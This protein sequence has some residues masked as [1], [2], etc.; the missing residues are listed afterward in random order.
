MSEMDTTFWVSV[1]G[2]IILL[3]LFSVTRGYRG[4]RPG[5]SKEAVHPYEDQLRVFAE[6][7]PVI[8]WSIDA[9]GLLQF[10]NVRWTQITGRDVEASMGTAWL[11]VIHPDDCAILKAAW[12]QATERGE[13]FEVVHRLQNAMGNYR[14]QRSRGQP[15]Q[16][17]EGTIIGWHGITDDIHE[18]HVAESTARESE[19]RL[20][21]GVSVGRLAIAEIDYSLDV[22]YTNEQIIALFGLPT[23]CGPTVSRTAIHMLVH[24]D[25]RPTLLAQIEAALDPA[26]ARW[27]AMEY[28]IVRPDGSIRWLNVRKQNFFEEDA[29]GLLYPARALLAAQDITEHRRVE[30]ALRDERD[31]FQRI[32]D[33]TPGVVH[34]YQQKADNTITFPYASPRIEEIYGAK[35]EQ[36]KE[37]AAFIIELWHPEDR[38]H[39]LDSIAKSLEQMSTWHDEF[40]V[41]HPSK[42][43][44]WVEGRSS[45]KLQAD[46]GILWYGVLT[47]ISERKAA[48][49]ALRETIREKEQALAQLDALFSAA[50]IGLGF[51]DT[52]LRFLRLNQTLAD[53]NGLPIDAQIGRHVAD[54]VPDL[55]DVEG[56]VTAWK[57]V[58]ETG[59]PIINIEIT[60]TTSANL[61]QQHYWLDNFFPVRIGEEIIGIGATVLDIT[62]R[63]LIE[64]EIKHLNSDLEER[65]EERTAQV[66][67]ANQEL[68]AFAYS[69]SHDLRSPLRAI[70]GYTRILLEDYTPRLD[71]EA[72]RLC[73]VVCNEAQRMGQLI[74][75]LLAFSRL[76]RAPLKMVPVDMVQLVQAIYGELQVRE[77]VQDLAFDLHPLPPAMGDP[78]MMRQVWQNLL[79]NAVKFSKQ[80]S[81][82]KIEVNFV[83]TERETIY[84]VSDNG[85]GFDMRYVGKL[86]GVFQRLHSA[87]EFPGTGVGLALVQRIIYRHGGR[88]WAEGAV[89][90]GA[91]FY[92]ALPNYG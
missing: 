43:E 53:I 4:R 45:P 2:T 48:E 77:Q 72:I 10:L 61:G 54:I 21:L 8:V 30:E 74:D 64:E 14:W 46:G 15:R 81:D 39:M 66:Q 71:A 47:D 62:E 59:K 3:L 86:F 11:A 49:Q 27:F 37:N 33:T 57:Q 7:I 17:K 52:D 16:S 50:P 60:G 63:K 13:A 36:L 78:T 20:R 26:S 91:T 70:D 24:P 44:I 31:R 92:F 58:I 56:M 55:G 89:G 32:V 40:R 41:R 5:S 23:D 1:A 34:A 83:A 35:P 18:L 38:A 90:V 84:S 51:W 75:D 69:V 28:R 12:Q 25:D 80:R 79:D 67:A 9:N 65:V 82:A 19:E 22:L 29:Q 68:E 73:N 42:G 76:G 6:T 87:Y 88:I 85:A